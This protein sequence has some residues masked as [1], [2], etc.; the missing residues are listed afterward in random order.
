[1]P[2]TPAPSI[3]YFSHSY[4]PD[5]RRVNMEVWKRLNELGVIFSVDPPDREK[6]PMDITFLE[7]MMQQSHCFIAIVPDRSRVASTSADEE[8][9]REPS[10]SPYQELEYRLAVR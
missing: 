1:M 10:W 7:R 6:R 3:A 5:D 8:D 9:R 4:R 2:E